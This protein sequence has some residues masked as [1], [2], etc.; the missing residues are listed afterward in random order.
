MRDSVKR[1]REERNISGVSPPVSVI[2]K[3]EAHVKD[4]GNW[5]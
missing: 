2:A 3:V 4:E 1:G 5:E